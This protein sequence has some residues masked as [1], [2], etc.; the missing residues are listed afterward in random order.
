MVGLI[1]PFAD[2]FR[3]R[4]KAGCLLHSRLPRLVHHKSGGPLQLLMSHRYTLQ[5]FFGRVSTTNDKCT[6]QSRIGEAAGDQ[7]SKRVFEPRVGLRARVRPLR[8]CPFVL[9]VGDL[10]FNAV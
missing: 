2:P 5:Q 10:G 6:K 7:L 1:F 3:R 4:L 9:F 8:L